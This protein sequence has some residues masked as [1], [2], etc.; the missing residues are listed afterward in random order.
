MREH[1]L[2]RYATY[3]MN[4]LLIIAVVLALYSMPR[5]DST[6]RYLKGFSD[7]IGPPS[8]PPEE[9]NLAILSWMAH[10]PARQTGGPNGSA[11]YRDLIETLNYPAL[12]QVRGSATNAFINLADS[13]GIEA[14]RLWGCFPVK[15]APEF[16]DLV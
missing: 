8:A 12:P 16:P 3:S 14:R 1:S 7:A 5:E 10:G 6:R 15:E 2:Y 11:L 9:K 4:G 13:G